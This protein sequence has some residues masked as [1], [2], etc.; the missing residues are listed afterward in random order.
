MLPE[1]LHPAIVHF[2]IVLAV[3]APLCF[4]ALFAAIHT[5]RLPQRSWIAVIVLQLA[6]TFSAWVTIETGEHEE[7][8]VERVVAER[9]IED[10]AE[11]AERFLVIAGLAIPLAIAGAWF[12]GTIGTA[13]RAATIVMS[14]AA[15]AAAGVTGHTGG[16]LVYKHGAASAY[17]QPG[18]A[19]SGPAGDHDDD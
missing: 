1:P 4:M 2:P 18:A 17:V 3:L 9:H 5:G 12:S 15:L 10:H 19:R 8:R 13:T 6:L 14:L 7:E 11:N 16:E